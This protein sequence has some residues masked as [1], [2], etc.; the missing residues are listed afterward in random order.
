[1]DR[2]QRAKFHGD[3]AMPRINVELIDD[4][5]QPFDVEVSY[6]ASHVTDPYST[7]NS[8]AEWDIQI[9][10]VRLDG[11][12]YTIMSNDEELIEEA[13]LNDLR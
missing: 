8:P 2:A 6:T 4:D 10:W 9:N 1:M 12:A 11:I 5:E 7:G 13:I 3:I